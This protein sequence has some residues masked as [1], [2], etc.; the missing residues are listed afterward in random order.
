MLYLMRHGQTDWNVE[1]RMQGHTDVPL[2]DTGRQMARDAREKYKD[3]HFDVCY[4]STL[5]RAKETAEIFLEGSGVP[6]IE[7]V[8]LME[9]GLGNYEGKINQPE[10][11]VWQFFKDPEH[12]QSENGVESMQEIMERIQS[13]FD[14]VVDPLL[15]EGKDILL[16]TH[17]GTSK[18]IKMVASNFAIHTI[19]EAGPI[20]NCELIKLK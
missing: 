3:I 9:I 19:R 20:G 12:Y 14:E 16:V 17:G 8:R 15:A 11:P 2:N 4:T 18:R 6:I 7:D 13:F 10:W 1:K 5:S